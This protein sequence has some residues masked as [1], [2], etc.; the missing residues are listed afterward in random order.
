MGRITAISSQRRNPD[1]YSI[2]IDGEFVL[3]IDKKTVEDMDLRVGKLVDEKDLKKITSQEEL[4]KAQAYALM[5]LGYRERSLREIKI[6]MRQKGYEEKLVE[7]VVKYL[8][9]RNLINDK[10]FT[11]LWAESRIKKGYGRWRIQSELEQKGVNRE[12]TDE[13]LK[14]LYSGI[15][16]VQVALDLVEKKRWVSK[17]PPRLTER[18]S[19]LLR[20]RGFSFEVISNVVE[21]IHKT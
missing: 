8:K 7:K 1:R 9:D 16:E 14:D 5:L 10:R 13:I 19:N 15:D 20:R 12:I 4:N 11:Q 2:F 3:G 18:V 21:K 17:E 6:R